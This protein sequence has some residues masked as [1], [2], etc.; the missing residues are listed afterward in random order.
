MNME[1][2]N[3]EVKEKMEK[4]KANKN[5]GFLDIR[6]YIRYLIN[7]EKIDPNSILNE[8]SHWPLVHVEKAI[9]QETRKII[10]GTK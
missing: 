5:A 2:A 3:P 10:N 6:K 4:I 1:K 9:K 8:V 7:V